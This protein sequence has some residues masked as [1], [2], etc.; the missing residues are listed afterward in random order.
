VTDVT[1]SER[2]DPAELSA[3]DEQLLRELT[4]PTV[5]SC[6]GRLKI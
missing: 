3:D 6:R 1:T 5:G 4:E 2:Q